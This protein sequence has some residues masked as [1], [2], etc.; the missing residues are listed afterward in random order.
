MRKRDWTFR[1]VILA[2]LATMS[3]NLLHRLPGSIN[4]TSPTTEGKSITL[5]PQSSFEPAKPTAEE[6]HSIVPLSQGPLFAVFEESPGKQ[7]H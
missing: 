1:L 2:V 6:Q 3:C 4:E 5:E 7:P